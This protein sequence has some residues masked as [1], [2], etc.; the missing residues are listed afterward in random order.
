MDITQGQQAITPGIETGTEA[1]QD[2]EAATAESEKPFA[3]L[4]SG[5]NA[6][7]ISPQGRRRI[8]VG[9]ANGVIEIWDRLTGSRWVSCIGHTDYVTSVAFNHDGTQVVSGSFDHT[10]RLWDAKTGQAIAPPFFGHTDYV[11]SVAFNHDGTQLVSG[12][13][14]NTIRLWDAKTGQAIAKPLSGHTSSVNSVAFSPDGT[15][16]VSGSNDKTLRLWD[17]NTGETLGQPL[18]GHTHYVTSV[19]FN[20]DGTQ[21]VSGSADKTVRLW[22]VNTGETLGQP[23]SG[24]TDYV[25]S[26]AFNHDGT[27]VISGSFDQ[28]LRLWDAS[29]GEGI[30]QPFSGHTSYVNAIACSP[31]GAMVVSGSNDKTL[32]LW[33]VSTGET[34]GQPFSG[35]TDYVTSVAFNHN[36]SRIATG[37]W[38][39]TVRLWNVNTGEAIGQP[40]IGHTDAVYSV[41]FSPD[42][43]LVISS[44]NDKTLRLWD[45]ET[46]EAISQPLCGHTSYIRSVAFSPD[47]T[48]IV[49]GSYDK[50]VRL[51]DV[52][53]GEATGQ[54]FIG[55]TNPVYA[56]EFSPDSKTVVSGSSDNT[57]R[58]WDVETGEAIG[59]P[60]I[61]HTDTVTSVA[62]SPDGTMVVSG[63]ADNTVRLW[64]INTGKVIGQPFIG[65]T[66]TVDSVAFSPDSK[67]VVSGSADNT[68]RLWD[69]SDSHRQRQ[70]IIGKHQREVYSVAFDPQGDYIISASKDGIKVWPWQRFNIRRIPQAFRNDQPTGEDS[71]DVAKELQSLADVLM[72]RS[73]QPP[74][75]VAILGS[76]GSGKSFGMHLIE[77]QIT[78]IRCH[79]ITAKQAW[80]DV[81]NEPSLSPYVGHVY[82]IKFNA[83]SYAKSD[84]WASLM[85]TIFDQLDRQLTLEKQLGEVSDLLAGG[86]IWRVVNQMND[87]DRKII[88]ESEL[89]QDVLSQLKDKNPDG[90]ALWEL[91]SQVR[92]EETEKLKRAE[93]ELQN[94]EAELKTKNQEIE[95]KFNQE[96][97]QLEQ[98]FNQEVKNI[99]TEMEEEMT[100]IS[101]LVVFLSQLKE[102]L[103]D[104]FGNSILKDFLNFCGFKDRKDL[105]TQFP[106]LQLDKLSQSNLL[107]IAQELIVS[108]DEKLQNI[109]A[110]LQKINHFLEEQPSQIVG[111][112]EFTKTDKKT[113]LIFLGACAVPFIVYFV[114]V[115]CIPN[116]LPALLVELSTALKLWLTS[117]TAIPALTTGMEIF[118]RV[119][120]LQVKTV[121]F[122]QAAREN[123]NAEREKINRT[124]EEKIKEQVN[125]RKL[126]YEQ[127]QVKQIYEK[128]ELAQQEI[129]AKRQEMENLQIQVE[130]QKQRVGLTAKYKSL[131]EFVNNRL[132]DNSY[133]KLL[134][135]MHQIQDDFADLSEHLIYR[136]GHT[137]PEKLAVL[138]KHFPRGPA[139]IVLYIDD[140]D[141]CP[142]D[143]VVQ[144]LEAVQL[145]LNTEIFVIILAIDDRY[146]GRALE[147]MYRG[148]LK[149]GANPS[150]VDYL[151]KIIQIPYRMRPIN[152]SVIESYLKSLVDI[153]ESSQI[154]SFSNL[155]QFTQVAEKSSFSLVDKLLPADIFSSESVADDSELLLESSQHHQVTQTSSDEDIEE[156]ENLSISVIPRKEAIK[157][158]DDKTQVSH[159]EN[160]HITPAYSVNIDPF[161]TLEKFTTEEFNWIKECCQHVD[162]TPRTAKR[163]I[164]IC[165]IIKIIWTPTENDVKHH[166]I[167]ETPVE[168]R[169]KQSLI[170]FLA[171]A[172]RY[173]KEMRKLLEEIY[174]EF[175][176]TDAESLIVHKH[177]WLNRLLKQNLF[178]DMYNQR[179]W[180]KFKNDFLKMPPLDEFLF[181]RRTFH[182]AISFCFIG[183]IG[184]D[185]DDNYNREYRVDNGQ[186]LY[187]FNINK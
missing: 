81:G 170:A 86:D 112:I 63:S 180:K 42:G 147:Y 98:V 83:W 11:T 138:K 152:K 80:G 139:R 14:D 132:E 1:E 102:T 87:S 142:P 21:V 140:L 157:D 100:D 24:H 41:A 10:V 89:S 55:H 19:A 155:S 68:V 40:F 61:G 60:F 111:L 9:L 184:Y 116:F 156:E 20:H 168:D 174:L 28:T 3:E 27:Q 51:W 33:H 75:A 117:V 173:P 125:Q 35:H 181:E 70:I 167:W 23:L 172:G 56:V 146:I 45:V 162:L 175:E 121:R 164:N 43:T 94:L 128:K 166:T 163:L 135:L 122:L 153:E 66:N 48:M 54:P 187:G 69:I 123:V 47:G 34:L 159:L 57:V 177:E 53:T 178:M 145:L 15:M 64:D 108:K 120:I 36:G 16:V 165:K 143:R 79:P 150:G 29:S 119:H 186:K 88:L 32:R 65:H 182:L 13:F 134:G 149:R 62:F 18:S 109:I 74:L 5:V 37:S 124:K 17:V 84:L 12:S 107:D 2:L 52:K 4:D 133:Q 127:H 154:H 141:R 73:L 85:Q 30:G 82:Q 118:K 26:A 185:P 151:E 169:F 136:H 49:S 77:Q 110:H 95:T 99:E 38:D 97:V 44:S 144:V 25:T 39:Q 8:A 101:I 67:T 31:D 91:L 171:L 160:K 92:Q 90:N 93:E 76:W 103:K 46:G 176:E 72:L 96:L 137:N 78:K 114:I 50:T 183:D 22:D 158:I 130:R 161:I 105:E 106:T 131:L 115:K 7:A 148:V 71:L 104:D 6:V 129:A 113:L 58:L 179:E 59:Q 126:E